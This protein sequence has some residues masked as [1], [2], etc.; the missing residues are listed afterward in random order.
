MIGSGMRAR[1]GSLAV[2]VV[3]CLG[4]LAPSASAVAAHAVPVQQVPTTTLAPSTAAPVT[5]TADDSS[6]SG[7]SI[8]DPEADRTIRRIVLALIGLAALLLLV[9]IVFWRATR[10][11]P[12]PLRRLSTMGTRSWRKADELKRAELLGPAPVRAEPAPGVEVAPVVVAAA[13]PAELDS[14]PAA[15][16][17][18][19]DGDG[20]ADEVPAEEGVDVVEV[21]EVVE[22]V[23]AAPS[24]EEPSASS[25]SLLADG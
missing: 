5:T 21:V 6:S 4:A 2:G 13:E 8:G 10:P 18:T 23:D 19:V 25:A 9:T 3:L 14:V 24:A 16:A 11:V 12:I 20:Q 22:V 1:L 17:A 7:A 15:V